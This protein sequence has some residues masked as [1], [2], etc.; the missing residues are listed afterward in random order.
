MS[1]WKIGAA[2]RR[3]ERNAKSPEK[4]RG[5]GQKKRTKKWCKGKAGVEHEPECRDYQEVKRS[6]F[7]KYANGWKILVCKKCGKDLDY[8]WG[9]TGG[10][11]REKP[12]WVT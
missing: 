3:D 8:W 1:D 10:R 4:V 11:K 5:E 7:G 12:E 2:K 9:E 6:L